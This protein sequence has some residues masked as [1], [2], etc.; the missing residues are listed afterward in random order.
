[1][2]QHDPRRS[3]LLW[4]ES[5]LLVV[6][7]LLVG[8]IAGV[9]RVDAQPDALGSRLEIASIDQSGFPQLGVNL[10]VTD[11]Q[12]RPL[13]DL[14]GLRL[15]EN[16]VPITE[17]E[18]L[19]A[20]VGIDVFF[21]ID[22]DTR[23]QDVEDEGG[24]TR[25]QKVQDSILNY[26][27]RF[28]DVAGRDHATV[29]VPGE[30]GGRLLVDDTT[31]PAT[32]IDAVRGY[33]PGRP[34]ESPTQAMLEMAV[35]QAANSKEAGRFQAI[36]VFTDAAGMNRHLFQPLV[37]EAQSLQVPFFGLLLGPP[38]NESALET[39]SWLTEP[40]RGFHVH[41]SD[42][43]DSAEIYQVLQDNGTQTQLR[44]RS[45]IIQSGNYSLRVTLDEEQDDATLSL[46]LEAPRVELILP[47]TTIRRTGTEADTE[48]GDLQPAVQPVG[49]L[50]EWPDELPRRL[51]SV[52]LQA[53]GERQQAPFVGDSRELQFEWDVSTLDAGSYALT[54]VVT[55][56]LG[57]SAQSEP[58][59]VNVEVSRPQPLPTETVTPTPSPL[60]ALRRALPVQSSL[61]PVLGF[62]AGGVLLLLVGAA[63]LR[64]LNEREAGVDQALETPAEEME[65]EETPPAGEP[66]RAVLEPLPEDAAGAAA[67]SVPDDNVTIGRAADDVDLVLEDKS[68]SPLHA[69][70]R[71][72]GGSFWLYDEGSEQGTL[73]NYER[74]GLAPRELHD[75]DEIQLG[76]V[77]L[78][79]RLLS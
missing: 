59:T 53:N 24:L 73:L 64:Y 17:Y 62:V 71:R 4:P 12:S 27:G 79:F 2:Q 61:T 14:Q 67:L 35:Q 37:E 60:A 66:L 63:V 77:R 72:R 30:E 51:D 36:V 9:S 47:Q 15:R 68:V 3:V 54:V 38:P 40:T 70:I 25:L 26:G 31:E 23:I 44:Y 22:A 8:L 39:I 21:V 1:M 6:V 65:G 41:M 57:F 10:I 33:D 49:A 52:S 56:T 58:E 18:R 34:A 78:R 55:D 42:A 69:R 48:L 13:R 46:A 76:R 45:N 43:A 5:H 20:P 16:S 74:L 50:I 19:Q 32:L 29:I 75:G 7:T 28:M 11:A